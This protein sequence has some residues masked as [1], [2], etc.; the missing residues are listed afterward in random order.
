[1]PFVLN[2]EGKKVARKVATAA[3]VG[4]DATMA[5]AVRLAKEDH[6]PYPPPS[7]PGERFHNRTGFLASSIQIVSPAEPTV[8]NIKGQWGA[9][10]NYALYVEIGTSCKDSGFP[11]A[12]QRA[13]EGMGDMYAIPGPSVPP[14]MAARYT[15]R[16]AAA[17]AYPMLAS[18][19]AAAYNS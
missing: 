3:A 12:Q 15:L 1:M 16:P 11:R 19:I 2:W 9:D 13:A 6:L 7:A 14:Q 10:A 8:F 17:E 18:F 4:I 5:E